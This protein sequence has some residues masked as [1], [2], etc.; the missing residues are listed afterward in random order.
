MISRI[1]A[2]RPKIADYPV[3]HAGPE[4]R[5]RR[6]VGRPI[7][8][9]R[10][11]ARADRRRARRAWPGPS[12]PEPSRTHQGAGAPRRRFVDDRPRSGRGLSRS[13]PASSQL[14]PGRD[15]AGERL[16]DKPRSSR[17]NKIDALDE[18]D[19]LDAPRGHLRD[20]R[21]SA[22]RCLCGHWRRARRRCSRRCGARSPRARERAASARRCDGRRTATGMNRAE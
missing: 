17:P 3:H 12:V 5:R 2:A 18:P 14:F 19:R 9:R 6:T 1:S 22:L 16:A 13:S 15:A 8:R 21:H 7:V 11:R 4:P 20:A 10:R